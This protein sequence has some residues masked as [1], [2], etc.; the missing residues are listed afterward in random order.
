MTNLILNQFFNN[1]WPTVQCNL[2]MSIVVSVQTAGAAAKTDNVVLAFALEPRASHWAPPSPAPPPLSFFPFLLSYWRIMKFSLILYLP[3]ALFLPL[4]A[5]L[6]LL[7]ST[8]SQSLLPCSINSDFICHSV[9]AGCLA[10]L[11]ALSHSADG[12]MRR[13]EHT[14]CIVLLMRPYILV[15][16]EQAC[17]T[18]CMCSWWRGHAC[19]ATLQTFT[20]TQMQTH[21]IVCIPTPWDF[22]LASR[23]LSK[24]CGN[25]Y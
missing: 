4:P 10:D 13:A 19:V 7:S 5:L 1:H 21:H 18:V 11:T 8:P 12:W 6:P 15:P 9:A 3:L 24:G 23:Q 22:K 16:R 17:V 2:L 14:G 20:R 25:A